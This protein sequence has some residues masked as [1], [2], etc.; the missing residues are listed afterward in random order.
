MLALGQVVVTGKLVSLQEHGLYFL[1]NNRVVPV[2][3][4]EAGMDLINIVESG[5]LFA[6][7]VAIVPTVYVKSV[8]DGAFQPA[9][10]SPRNAWLLV[11]S[12]CRH[13]DR[14][15]GRVHAGV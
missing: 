11:C 7:S 15:I 4:A 2:Q 1:T 14:S 8:F 3:F 5:P 13:K 12:Y 6:A 9:L 10:H